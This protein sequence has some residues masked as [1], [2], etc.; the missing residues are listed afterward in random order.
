MNIIVPT[1][2]PNLKKNITFNKTKSKIELFIKLLSCYFIVY[3]NKVHIFQTRYTR[4]SSPKGIS[5]FQ[6]ASRSPFK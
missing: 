1:I 4:N 3:S 6:L 2:M 5:N